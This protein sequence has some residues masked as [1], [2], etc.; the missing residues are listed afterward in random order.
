MRYSRLY[1]VQHKKHET[2]TNN[3]P[4]YIQINKTNSRLELKIKDSH[5]VELQTAP[6]KMKLF[7][8]TKKLIDKTTNRENVPSIQ[9]FEIVLVQ[10]NLVDNQYQQKSEVLHTFRLINIMLT[11]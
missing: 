3:A 6:E 7:S 8:S 1:Q 4:I 10:C 11:C 2:L 9:M 5:N